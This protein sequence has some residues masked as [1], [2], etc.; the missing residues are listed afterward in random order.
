M[1]KGKY[2]I[3]NIKRQHTIIDGALPILEEI[4]Q[5]KGIKRVIPSKIHSIGAVQAKMKKILPNVNYHSPTLKITR[6]VLG[7]FKLS[8]NNGVAL[9]EV[10]VTANT[11]KKSEVRYKIED[12]IFYKFG[13]FLK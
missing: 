1:K 2:D 12:L 5:I 13:K 4:S 8:I 6:E 11:Q 10:I 7:G 3:K 9:Q